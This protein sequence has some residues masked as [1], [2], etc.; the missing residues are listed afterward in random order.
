MNLIKFNRYFQSDD[1]C[2]KY[3]ADV[4]LADGYV[5]RKCGHMQYYRGSKSHSCRCMKCKYNE[6]PTTGTM[7]DIGKDISTSTITGVIYGQICGL[8][9]ITL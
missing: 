8:Y 4:K 1:D 7:F 9:S 2:C 6:S 3:L 5:C